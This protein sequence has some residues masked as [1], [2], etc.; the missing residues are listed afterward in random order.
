[1]T[2]HAEGYDGAGHALGD[3]TAQTTFSIQ[4]SAAKTSP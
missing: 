2:Y 4:F 3:V 1:L